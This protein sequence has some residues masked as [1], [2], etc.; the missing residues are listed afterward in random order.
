MAEESTD[1]IETFASLESRRVKVIMR[2]TK[3]KQKVP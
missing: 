1:F 2:R 3:T